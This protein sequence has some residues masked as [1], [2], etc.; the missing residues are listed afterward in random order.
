MS[1]H[2]AQG[3][4]SGNGWPLR[5][6]AL[7]QLLV[8]ALGIFCT[9]AGLHGC[10]RQHHSRPDAAASP[11]GAH[12]HQA[13]VVHARGPAPAD[14]PAGSGECNCLGACQSG[15]VAAL[16]PVSPGLAADPATG[17]AA[18]PPGHA[19]ALPSVRPDYFLP[20]PLG[21]PTA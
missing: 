21:P 20:Y 16:R 15:T 19:R 12:P 10:P 13:P 3:T 2:R 1:T 18:P 4:G 14:A 5:Y 6:G 11:G 17:P 8:F 7:C 9:A